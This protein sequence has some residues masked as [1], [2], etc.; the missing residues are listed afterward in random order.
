MICLR[1]FGALSQI[2]FQV[3][4]R[5]LRPRKDAPKQTKEAQLETHGT[6]RGL[7]TAVFVDL[8]CDDLFFGAPAARVVGDLCV[9]EAHENAVPHVDAK[10]ERTVLLSLAWPKGLSVAALTQSALPQR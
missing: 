5:N 3:G 2:Y 6:T 1:Y 10:P 4:C 8:W 7:P 9:P